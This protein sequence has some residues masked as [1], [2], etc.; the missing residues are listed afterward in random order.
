MIFV[1]R[2]AVIVF[3]TVALTALIGGSAISYGAP[4]SASPSK[5]PYSLPVQLPSTKDSPAVTAQAPYSRSCG[6]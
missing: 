6:I 1:R 2:V 3:A 4:S 5:V